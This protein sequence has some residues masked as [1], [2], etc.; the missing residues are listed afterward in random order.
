MLAGLILSSDVNV[1]Y[2]LLLEKTLNIVFVSVK[3][4]VVCVCAETCTL[5]IKNNF[6]NSFS[7][8]ERFINI[9]TSSQSDAQ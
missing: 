5:P 2:L 1:D 8:N 4:D 9:S 7:L 3:V 6:Y